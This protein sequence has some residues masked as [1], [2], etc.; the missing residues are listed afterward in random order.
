MATRAPT[1]SKNSGGAMPAVPWWG[2][3][4]MSAE[5]SNG[6][7]ASQAPRAWLRSPVKRAR[8]RP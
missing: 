3:F 2:S 8:V 6:L 5:T 1:R 4:K 7:V